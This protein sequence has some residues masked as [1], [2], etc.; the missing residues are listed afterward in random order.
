MSV[1]KGSNG[2][3]FDD[4]EL[5]ALKQI[6]AGVKGTLWR[7]LHQLVRRVGV[8]ICADDHEPPQIYDHV[9]CIYLLVPTAH[10][11]NVSVYVDTQFSP[12]CCPHLHL[13]LCTYTH[14]ERMKKWFILDDT[15]TK[16]AIH[17]VG[18]V[19]LVLCSVWCV[20][21]YIYIYTHLKQRALTFPEC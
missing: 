15:E 19:A 12:C 17:C 7:R 20:Y 16:H 6:S 21:V 9:E 13:F 4:H 11:W 14:I 2:F 5:V 8:D 3:H 1:W 10:L 18:Y